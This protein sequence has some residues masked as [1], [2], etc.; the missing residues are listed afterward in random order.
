MR[1][2]I[3]FIRNLCADRFRFKGII[4]KYSY[5]VKAKSL[6]HLQLAKGQQFSTV[7]IVLQRDMIYP[8]SKSVN[9]RKDRRPVCFLKSNR[10]SYAI[11]GFHDLDVSI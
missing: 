7:Q 2:G 8:G 3:I 4:R 6:P 11:K 10:G 9:V 5:A 1:V